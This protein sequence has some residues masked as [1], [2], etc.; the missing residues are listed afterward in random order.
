[1][2]E[3]GSIFCWGNNEWGQ[4]G[5]PVDDRRLIPTEVPGIE[6]AIEVSVGSRQTCARLRSD[7]IVCWGFGTTMAN[8]HVAEIVSATAHARKLSVGRDFAA[9]VTPA[10]GIRWWTMGDFVSSRGAQTITNSKGAQQ[11]S[12]GFARICA[13]MKNGEVACW[14]P[15][16]HEHVDDP[17]SFWEKGPWRPGISDAVSV[18]IRDT[19]GCVLKKNGTVA[20]WGLNDLG[21]LGNGTDISKPATS[22]VSG[23]NDAIGIAV[24]EWGACVLRRVGKVLCWGNGGTWTLGDGKTHSSQTAIEVAGIDDATTITAGTWHVCARRHSG[25]VSCWGSNALG[26]IGDGTTDDRKEPVFVEGLTDATY[27]S[28]GMHHTCAIRANGH[29][30]CWG[31]TKYGQLGVMPTLSSAVAVQVAGWP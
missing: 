19:H 20:C 8:N 10:D 4:L 3:N 31:S 25:R 26:Q 29:V 17:L 7:A 2:D 27:V 30:V 13:V 21:Q 5:V 14:G 1:M 28:A 9:M 6:G 11:V 15:D 23:V 22:L 18:A 16:F 12:V 24:T